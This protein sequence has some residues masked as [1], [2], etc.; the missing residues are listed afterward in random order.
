LPVTHTTH[1]V[2]DAKAVKDFDGLGDAVSVGGRERGQRGV[3][4]VL[5][6]AVGAAAATGQR[7][8]CRSGQ[9]G[10]LVGVARAVVRDGD[11]PA[12]LRDEGRRIY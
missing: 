11:A 1:I 4:P 2:F 3:A 6:A 8:A 10:V 7:C 12:V 5:G 9:S